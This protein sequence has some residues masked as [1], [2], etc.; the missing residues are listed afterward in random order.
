MPQ[1]VEVKLRASPLDEIESLAL[2]AGASPQGVLLQ[3]DTFFQCDR[4]R[5]KLREIEGAPA[6]LIAYSRSD[7]S[8]VRTSDYSIF[9][10]DQPA[11][12]REVL[13]RSLGVTV[14]VSKRR[15]LLLW[16]NVRIHL[17]RVDGLGEFVEL[18]SVV[19]DVDCPLAAQNLDELLG[20]LDL[21]AAE[22]VPVAYADLLAGGG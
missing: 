4:G 2:R 7:E 13:S 9:R 22:I 10:T 16:R 21:K 20:L 1:N 18:E 14:T 12:L 19:G 8:A 3:R 6:E 5:L 15:T 17:D 11:S